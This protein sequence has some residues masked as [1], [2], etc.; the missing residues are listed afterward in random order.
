[1]DLALAISITGRYGALFNCCIAATTHCI[2]PYT[3]LP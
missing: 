3:V 2:D 1:M